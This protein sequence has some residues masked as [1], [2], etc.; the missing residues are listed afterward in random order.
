ME[1]QDSKQIEA[2]LDE[3]AEVIA[4]EESA[5]ADYEARRAA[6]LEKVKAELDALDAEYAPLFAAAAERRTALEEAIKND[7]LNW[8]ASVRGSQWHAVYYRGRVTW[9]THG[10]EVYAA[11]HP[12]VNAFRKEGEPTVVLRAVK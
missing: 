5:H 7:V 12:E 2:R 9:D 3:L 1:T 10:L 11:V 6:I 8:G 4:A